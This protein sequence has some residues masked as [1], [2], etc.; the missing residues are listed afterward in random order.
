MGADRKPLTRAEVE[1]LY[2]ERGTLAGADLVRADLR[3]I[4]LIEADLSGADLTRADLTDAHLFGANLQGAD[5]FKAN[6]EGAN[7]NGADLRQCNLLATV[8]RNTK[9][10]NVVLDPGFMVVNEQAAID[11]L[12]RGDRETAHDK[13][14]EARDVYRSLKLALDKQISSKDVGMLFVREMSVNRKLMP[15]YSL[16]RLLSKFLHVS[17]G[18]GEQIGRIIG[19]IFVMMIASALVFGV[20]GVRYGDQVLRFGSEAGLWATFGNLLY[21]S[22]V[23]FTTVGFGDITP[24]GPLGKITVIIEGIGGTI[25]IAILVIAIYKRSMTR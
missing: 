15:R 19:S 9:L 25:Y 10:S 17:L 5:L 22:V 13:Y 8:F 23:V 4:H 3:D 24:F 21:F 11:A 1:A 16:Q 18:Y 6:L 7:L 20:E 14:L 2:A 12:R